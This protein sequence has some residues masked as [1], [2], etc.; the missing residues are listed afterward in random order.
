MFESIKIKKAAKEFQAKYNL[1]DEE[2]KHIVFHKLPRLFSKPPIK[3]DYVGGL[4]PHEHNPRLYRKITELHSV[5]VDKL[6]HA[7]DNFFDL[8]KKF[9]KADVFDTYK[10]ECYEDLEDFLYLFQYNSSKTRISFSPDTPTE[11]MLKIWDK[12]DP[13]LT[14]ICLYY[15]LSLMDELQEYSK[16]SILSMLKYLIQKD[17]VDLNKS[18]EDIRSFVIEKFRNLSHVDKMLCDDWYNASTLK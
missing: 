16:I 12:A 5:L 7:K 11:V 14:A 17:E 18:Y 4:N 15:L 2:M 10:N 1:S 13:F 3:Y 6:N 9:Q 8:T